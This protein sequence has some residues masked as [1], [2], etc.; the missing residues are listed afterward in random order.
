MDPQL[1]AILAVGA[2]ALLSEIFKRGL[3]AWAEH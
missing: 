2:V 3:E 1:M